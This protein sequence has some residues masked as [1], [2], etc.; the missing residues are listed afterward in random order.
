MYTAH[1]PA[2][3]YSGLEK[4]ESMCAP[5]SCGLGEDTEYGTLWGNNQF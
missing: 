3:F 2:M 5:D 4:H 1:F